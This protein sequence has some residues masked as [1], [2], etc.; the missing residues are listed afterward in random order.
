LHFTFQ[1]LGCATLHCSR[2]HN[3]HLY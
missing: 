3:A 2:V 1:V